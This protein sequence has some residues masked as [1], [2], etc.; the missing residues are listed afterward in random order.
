M[1]NKA[2]LSLA[3]VALLSLTA[4]HD[5]GTPRA[6]AAGEPPTEANS[7]ASATVWSGLSG[8]YAANFNAASVTEYT[9]HASGDVTP[10]RT[11]S[12]PDT[13]IGNIRDVTVDAAGYIYT[14]NLSGPNFIT[15]FAPTAQGDARPIRQIGGGLN[16]L[17]SDPL[18]LAVDAHGYIYV[19]NQTE[20][21]PPAASIL[22]FAPGANGNVAPVRQ[23]T[24]AGE[25]VSLAIDNAGD[26]VVA[27]TGGFS[28]AQPNQIL[29][30]APGAHG[31]ATP[32][33]RIAGPATLLGS[34]DIVNE[35][36]SVAVLPGGMRVRAAVSGSTGPRV[37]V[38]ANGATG[39]VAPVLSLTGP[40][41]QLGTTSALAID[42]NSREYVANDATNTITVYGSNPS[43]NMAPVAVIAGPHTGLN[44]TLGLD[45]GPR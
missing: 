9:L 45:V 1:L 7:A 26:L 30:Y 43:G 22:V 44:D 39:N 42:L 16:T 11:I 34:G 31:N 18:A 41:T 36:F 10:V 15:I 20:E 5:A 13:G 37:N 19:A 23:I 6:T 25:A 21:G 27:S 33:G 24:G 29:V 14:V 40:A 3:L 2:C 35:G 12:G 4:G 17:L 28:L 32:I 8:L 38:Y